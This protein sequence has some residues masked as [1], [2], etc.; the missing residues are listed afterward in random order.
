MPVRPVVVV[1]RSDT[2][3][4]V[5]HAVGGIVVD[6][7]QQARTGIGHVVTADGSGERIGVVGVRRHG[8][9][10]DTVDIDDPLPKSTTT[11]T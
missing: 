6:G 11:A 9:H 7:A 2:L 5:L 10:F 4:A 8:T 1:A 3:A